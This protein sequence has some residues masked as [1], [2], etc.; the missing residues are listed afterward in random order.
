M[1]HDRDSVAKAQVPIRFVSLDAT[2]P[3]FGA[4]I[5]YAT[6]QANPMLPRDFLAM[7]HLEPFAYLL[8]G[9]DAWLDL[10]GQEAE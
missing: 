7:D 2:G 3:E 9:A 10:A 4:R 6:N 5:A 1:R 8:A